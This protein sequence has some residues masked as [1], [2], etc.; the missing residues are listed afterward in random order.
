[1]EDS[2]WDERRPAIAKPHQQGRMA[3]IT[4]QNALIEIQMV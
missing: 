2:D 4:P 3:N 1:M